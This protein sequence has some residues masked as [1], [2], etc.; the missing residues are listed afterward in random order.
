MA[1]QPVIDNAVLPAAALDLIASGN[2]AG[3]DTIIG[4]NAEEYRAFV[5]EFDVTDPDI[6][7]YFEE[8]ELSADDV[9]DVYQ[10]ARP[11]HSRRDLLCAVETDRTFTVPA[12]R[13]AEHQLRA[14]SSVWMYRFSWRTP[15]LDGRL[16][17]CHGLELPFVFET[18]HHPRTAVLVG[19]DPPQELSAEMHA[20]WVR[21]AASGDP[22]GR[23][24]PHWPSYDLGTRRVMNFDSPHCSVIRD[25]DSRERQLWDALL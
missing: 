10:S 7:D 15:V 4:T 17:A 2:S 24:L 13:L 23:G 6:G 14:T 18:E 11:T 5:M 3:V 12:V 20:A 25:P 1:F 22:N 8:A 19:S 21:F 16:G 9:L